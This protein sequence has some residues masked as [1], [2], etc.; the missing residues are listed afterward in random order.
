MKISTIAQLREMTPFEEL[1]KEIIHKMINFI[2]AH[3]NPMD[4][5]LEVWHL[6]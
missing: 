6:T 3:E 1:E 4:Q 5:K 2:D